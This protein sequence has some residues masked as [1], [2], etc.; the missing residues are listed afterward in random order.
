[1]RLDL[2]QWFMPLP[3]ASAA[4]AATADYD[5]N[6]SSVG[7]D[8][9]AA[10]ESTTNRDAAGFA[11]TASAPTTDSIAAPRISDP[12]HVSILELITSVNAS[13]DIQ[14]FAL[15]TWRG[16]ENRDG[17]ILDIERLVWGVMV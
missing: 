4:T 7:E 15:A 8:E 5:A 12:E 3:T 13:A 6:A 2:L 11:T 14:G 10:E 17:F 16:V 1:M 9:E